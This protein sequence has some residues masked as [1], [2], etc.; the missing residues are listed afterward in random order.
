MIEINLLPAEYQ[1]KLPPKFTAPKLPVK[2]TFILIAGFVFGLQVLLSLFAGYQA[3]HLSIVKAQAARL[4]S[5]NHSVA[6]KKS[7]IKATQD[8][9][10][11]IWLVTDRKYVWASLLNALSRSVTKGVWLT[12][13][14]VMDPKSADKKGASKDKKDDKN[15]ADPK[16]LKLSGSVVGQGEETAFTGKFIKELKANTVFSRLF[17]GI[18]LSSL[19][20]KKIREFD[21]YD[22]S[23]TC[24][25]RSDKAVAP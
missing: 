22:F 19:V 25:F 12:G 2:K 4:E 3:L 18:E 15:P 16:I 21:V 14:S 10:R 9:L 20:Q 7:Q 23:I 5:E 13:F 6:E 8:H 17:S 11:K 1:P 24:T